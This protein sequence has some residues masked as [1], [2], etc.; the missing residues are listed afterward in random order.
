MKL[1]GLRMKIFYAR[2]TAAFLTVPIITNTSEQ[3]HFT[4]NASYIEK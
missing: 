2:M 4:I 1:E 3:L